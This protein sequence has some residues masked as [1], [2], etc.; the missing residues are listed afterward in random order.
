MLLVCV[1]L[2]YFTFLFV[3]FVFYRSLEEKEAFLE[4]FGV[5]WEKVEVSARA[6]DR[7]RP[8]IE[9]TSTRAPKQGSSTSAFTRTRRRSIALQSSAPVRENQSSRSHILEVFVLLI[10]VAQGLKPYDF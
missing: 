6:I 3:F 4:I 5:K 9:G 10:L 7:R 1:I 2:F 8:A